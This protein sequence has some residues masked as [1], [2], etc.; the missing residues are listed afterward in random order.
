[1]LTTVIIVLSLLLLILACITGALWVS[2]KHL[3][4]Q[5]STLTIERDEARN[6]IEA[7]GSEVSELKTQLELARQELTQKSAAFEQAQTQSRETFAT[8]ANE[9]LNKTSEQF[10]QLAK[11]S[12]ES[13]N[14]DAAA[15]LEQRKQAIESMLKPIREQLENHAKA[16]TEMEKN[17]EGAYQGLRQQITGLLESQQHLSQTTTQLSTALKGSAGT[18]GRWGELALKRI[19]ELAGMVNHVDF[20]EQVSIWKGNDQQRPDMVVRLPA[21]RNIVIDSKAVGENYLKAMECDNE[22]DR[23]ELFRLHANQI[24]GRVR[25]L[26]RKDYT[27]GFTHAP[28]FVVLFIP[29]DSFLTPAMIA[30]PTLVEDAL[31][32]NVVIATPTTLVSLL[33]VIAMGWREEQLAENAQ[34]VTEQA[35]VLHERVATVIG[36][37][38]KLGKSLDTAVSHYN[39]MTSSFESRVLV[40]TKRLEEM[41]IKS[42]KKLPDALPELEAAPREMR[43]TESISESSDKTDG[44]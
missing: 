7:S 9:T 10:L 31:S 22:Q 18:R 20:D 19:V 24:E 11:K 42:A 15:A 8:L 6:R 35:T 16:V 29:G 37:M 14:K 36:H 44:D 39:K 2:R 30:K 26:S 23:T 32:R 4:T 43:T 41:G 3:T 12:L 13:E 27:T 38:E 40:S 1:M 25:D 17:R 33:K 34:K 28:D 5:V 21:D